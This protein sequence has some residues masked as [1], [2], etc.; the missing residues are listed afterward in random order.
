MKKNWII[1]LILFLLAANVAF[2]VT[3]IV[4]DKY[5][6]V[7]DVVEAQEGR[8]VR[9]GRGRFEEHVSQELKFSEAQKIQMKEFK[10]DFNQNKCGLSKGMLDLK[11]KYFDLLS[12]EQTNNDELIGIA[13]SLG[14]LHAKIILLEYKYYRELRS[15]CDEEQSQ[16]LD[17]LS[18]M[19]LRSKFYKS[20]RNELKRRSNKNNN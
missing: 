14:I 7:E 1:I 4:G 18:L 15:I 2:V 17:S 5:A 12:A 11:T 3:L 13:D 6:N 9:E 16:Q 19:H 20:N 8:R 10:R